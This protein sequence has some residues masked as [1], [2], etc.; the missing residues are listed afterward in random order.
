MNHHSSLGCMTPKKVSF[1]VVLYPFHILKLHA[2][3][4]AYTLTCCL[5][6]NKFIHRKN[7]TGWLLAPMSDSLANRTKKHK[8]DAWLYSLC[9]L[10]LPLPA[11]YQKYFAGQKKKKVT[12]GYEAQDPAYVQPA[13]TELACFL[14]LA[15]LSTG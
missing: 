11:L 12:A 15:P 10:R 5:Y 2:C 13:Q 14:L 7:F 9:W 6:T 1:N 8:P 3:K 4:D